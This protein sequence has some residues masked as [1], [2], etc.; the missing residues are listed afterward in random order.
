[1]YSRPVNVAG[2]ALPRLNYD[3]FEITSTKLNTQISNTYIFYSSRL[4]VAAKKVDW[5]KITLK[6][7]L[8]NQ[9]QEHLKVV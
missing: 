6:H 2:G 4:V 5:Q 3:I 9:F 8:S 7:Y 1:M